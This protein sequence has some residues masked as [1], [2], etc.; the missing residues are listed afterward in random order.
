MPTLGPHAPAPRWGAL[1]AIALSVLALAATACQ[2]C[3]LP[4]WTG[5]T[6]TYDADDLLGTWH[7]ESFARDRDACQPT[8]ERPPNSYLHVDITDDGELLLIP[9][10]QKDLD[11]C[12]PYVGPDHNLLWSDDD[13]RA[14]TTHF[15][16]T[17]ESEQSIHSD[18]RL[19]ATRTLLTPGPDT[20]E[21]TRSHY[22]LTLPLEGDQSCDPDHA[23]DHHPS[24]PCT[25]SEIITVIRGD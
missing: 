13:Q 6:P 20:L 2:G 5:I 8:P 19:S 3:D 17:L 4:A 11:A 23:A 25:R 21:I 24:L 16:A 12:N 14:D 10:Q 9:C 15:G 22:E 7:V 1:I 18:C